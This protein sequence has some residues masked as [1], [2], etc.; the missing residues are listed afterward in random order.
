MRTL[1]AP[2]FHVGAGRAFTSCLPT[3]GVPRRRPAP[4]R[5]FLADHKLWPPARSRAPAVQFTE[6]PE[7][8]HRPLA[9]EEPSPR[10]EKMEERLGAPSV[11]SNSLPASADPRGISA[12]QPSASRRRTGRAATPSLLRSGVTPAHRLLGRCCYPAPSA[13]RARALR[14]EPRPPIVTRPSSRR[15]LCRPSQRI[16]RVRWAHSSSY[17]PPCGG[18]R[19]TG[20]M[21][22]TD[23]CFPRTSTTSTRA[24][25]VPSISPRPAPRPLATGL[26]PGAKETGGHGVSRRRIR[27]GGGPWVRRAP[28]S[29]ASSLGLRASDTLVAS[30]GPRRRSR[31]EGYPVRPR[32][33]ASGDP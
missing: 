28:L 22:S 5:R 14:R 9:F 7:S 11:V 20:A 30:P 29:G 26:R 33:R 17:G 19:S 15:A 32:P 12:A 21:R 6:R 18:A 10:S 16:G 25:L 3:S 31:G 24:T 4:V 27:F 1:R 2:S 8:F 23:F 13:V